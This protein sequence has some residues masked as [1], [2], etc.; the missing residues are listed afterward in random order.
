LGLLYLALSLTLQSKLLADLS[1]DARLL[2]A[3]QRDS[4]GLLECSLETCEQFGLFIARHFKSDTAAPGNDVKEPLL[5]DRVVVLV[6]QRIDPPQVVLQI[7]LCQVLATIVEL[8]L[9]STLCIA[10]QFKLAEAD[11]EI[12]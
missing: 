1:F 2:L 7:A 10:I 12:P 8:A 3:F 5:A 6:Q 11:M 4:N 9:Q